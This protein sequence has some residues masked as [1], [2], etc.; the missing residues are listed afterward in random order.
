[1]LQTGML[2]ASFTIIAAVKT[3]A[4]AEN[5]M[6]ILVLSL[7]ILSFSNPLFFLTQLC[8]DM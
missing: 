6:R 1:M 7:P 8:C 2:V 3:I 5:C 4:R